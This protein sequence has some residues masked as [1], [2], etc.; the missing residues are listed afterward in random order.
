MWNL[1]YYYFLFLVFFYPNVLG[2]PDNYIK[3]NP[4]CTPSHI[5]PEWYFLPFYT[6]LRAVPNKVGG[7]I[8]MGG[9]IIILFLLPNIDKK[10][11]FRSPLFRFEFKIIYWVFVGTVV[12]LMIFGT[13]PAEEP[14]IRISR[15]LT[16]YYFSYFLFLLPSLGWVEYLAMYNPPINELNKPLCVG[17]EEEPRINKYDPVINIYVSRLILNKNNKK[18]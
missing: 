15:I 6:I 7:V 1:I 3:A 9:S 16:L 17:L 2:H 13:L 4:L 10:S 12:L 18:I 14:F 5:V 8:L 11:P